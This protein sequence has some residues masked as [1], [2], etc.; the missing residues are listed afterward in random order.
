MRKTFI[1]EFNSNTGY[2]RLKRYRPKDF[3]NSC[4]KNYVNDLLKEMGLS[5]AELNSDS[6]MSKEM[7][8]LLG[9]IFYPKQ[10]LE[11]TKSQEQKSKI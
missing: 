5:G 10:L 8:M 2:I 4:L 7:C 6:E 1:T 11:L 9:A 3:L